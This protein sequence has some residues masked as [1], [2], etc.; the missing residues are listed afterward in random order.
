MTVCIDSNVLLGMFTASHAHRPI[1][2]AWL[3]KL[4][5]W[6]VSTEIL[7]EYEEIM[8]REGGTVKAA[9][10]MQIMQMAATAHGNLHLVSPTYRFH[11]ITDDPDDDKFT[12]CAMTSDADWLITSDG[13]FGRLVSSGYKP[14]PIT[15]EDFINRFLKP[16]G[17]P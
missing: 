5:M 7:L 6:A 16:R 9:K 14:Q 15:P 12:D 2:D 3:Q 13:H 4:F 1:L 17:T 10:M 11:L 8:L